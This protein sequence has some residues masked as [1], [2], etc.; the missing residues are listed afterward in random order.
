ME[1]TLEDM[2]PIIE[3]ILT[4]LEACRA[5]LADFPTPKTFTSNIQNLEGDGDLAY[6]QGQVRATLDDGEEITQT[7]LAI[8]RKQEDGS[9]KMARDM[10]VT[11]E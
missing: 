1:I 10:W 6:W 11:P 9:W 7:F 8:A 4:A 3:Q 2:K 5:Y